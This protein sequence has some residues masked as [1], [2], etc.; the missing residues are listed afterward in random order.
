[1][2]GKGVKHMPQ[3][4]RLYFEGQ[5]DVEIDHDGE[6]PEAWAEAIAATW[7]TLHELK[8]ADAA[9]MTGHAILDK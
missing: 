8:I 1:M 5:V 3:T 6:D 7:E 2:E 9:N 4:V